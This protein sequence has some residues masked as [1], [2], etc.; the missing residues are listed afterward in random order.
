MKNKLFL[1]IPYH[2]EDSRLG[3][4]LGVLN[5]ILAV[6]LGD[7][8]PTPCFPAQRPCSVSNPLTPSRFSFPHLSVEMV[9]T[10]TRGGFSEHGP[11]THHYVR[12]PLLL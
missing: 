4:Q 7:P 3:N 5:R 11:W 1:F 6:D 10:P 8:G 9:M 2:L 12:L